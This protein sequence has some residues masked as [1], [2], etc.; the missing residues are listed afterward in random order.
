MKNKN[1]IIL[2]GIVVFA[3]IL[4]FWQLGNV[5]LSPDWDEVALGYDAYSILHTGRDEFGAF[6]PAVLRSFDDYKPALYAYLAIPTVAMFGL[7][8]FAVRLPSVVMGIVGV[9]AIYFLVKELFGIYARA[10][11]EKNTYAEILALVSAFLMAIS[12]W[13][14][15]FSRTAFET[16]TGL[17]FN[18]LLGLFFLKGLKKPWMLSL[19]AFFAGLNLAVYQSERV[20]TPLLVLALVIIYWKELL[21]VS[22][23]YLI[24]C[25]VVG[26]LVSLPTIMY[27][28]T[29]VNSLERAAG[30]SVVSQNTQ[31]LTQNYTRL[32][33][34]KANH[35]II[36][37]VLDNRRV[38]YVKEIIAGYLIHF[39]PNWLF[40]EGDNDRHHAPGMGI[41]YIL[42][43]PFILLGIY[44]FIFNKFPKKTKYLVF[45]WLFL[46]PVPAAFTI[47]VP[48]A[49]R[50]MNLLPMLLIFA[51]LGYFSVFQF[52]KKYQVS[53]GKYQVF[54]KGFY[55]VF[56]VAAIFNF[57]YYL[58]QYFVQQ[59]YYNAIDW[60]YGYA[61]AIPEIES[62]Q[63]QYQKIIVSDK[64][65]M[66]E[67]YMFFLFYLKYP[68]QQY[69]QL[70]AQGENIATNE[71]QF[72]K[73]DFRTFNWTTEKHK[74]D[75]LYVGTVNDFPSN[76]IA[77]KT[78]YY[79]N[80]SPAILLVDPRNN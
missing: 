72:G 12:P 32:K 19:A 78:I 58:N 53:S 76:V 23:K 6:M 66:D 34:D 41:M 33:N 31:A 51:A 36:G 52:V 75:V 21:A 80:G 71:H 29:H 62:L 39:N 70:V 63:N 67:S 9:I 28:F 14:I 64:T 48:H 25:I 60:Q 74:Q 47:D 79:P 44:L 54:A 42:D 2:I 7:T 26:L 57:I 40:L 59:N 73:Y 17:T 35:D 18:L 38:I 5:P 49:V 24:A 4:R 55:V 22:K 65:P 20:F 61:Q 30:T 46:A 43:L 68:P 50:T 8:V 11:D 37:L 13:Q 56:F 69:Q 27:V 15:Q 16:N 3:F 1:N 10:P 77:K 45:S